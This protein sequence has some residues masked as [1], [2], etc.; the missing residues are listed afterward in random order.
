MT[1]TPEPGDHTILCDTVTRLGLN[2]DSY[3]QLVDDTRALT[4]T[5][6]FTLMT[7]MITQALK[8]NDGTI[9]EEELQDI[10]AAVNQTIQNTNTDQVTGSDFD[11]QGH[12]RRV[13]RSATQATRRQHA[14]RDLRLLMAATFVVTG[15]ALNYTFTG[16]SAVEADLLR[17]V[18][19]KGVGSTI[20]LT[21]TPAAETA[22]RQ[23]GLL[24]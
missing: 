13:R 15:H 20:N 7:D 14:G 8:D 19:S 24:R 6:K 18:E 4:A 22:A 1:A 12:Q 3:N 9:G 21:L 16:V 11:A 10:E 5:R 2:A 17:Q 23:H